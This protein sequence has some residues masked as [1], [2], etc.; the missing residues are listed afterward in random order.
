MGGESPGPLM[1]VPETM[2]KIWILTRGNG[3]THPM[4]PKQWI[5]R[6][7]QDSRFKNVTVRQED[8]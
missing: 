2:G 1:G 6:V 8:K 3:S 4:G 7:G 5:T